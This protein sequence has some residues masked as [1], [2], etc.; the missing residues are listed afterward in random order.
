MGRRG[1]IGSLGEAVWLC[2]ASGAPGSAW[3]RSFSVPCPRLLR[4]WRAAAR[5]LDLGGARG[6]GGPL[7]GRL[8]RFFDGRCEESV[9]STGC[10]VTATPAGPG[11]G[12]PAP[13]RPNPPDD[14][15]APSGL[16][17][18]GRSTLTVSG[19]LTSPRGGS[20]PASGATFSSMARLGAWSGLAANSPSATTSAATP[21]SSRAALT[22]AE[23]D[24]TRIRFVWG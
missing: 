1:V 17:R 6:F 18:A 13:I 12:R 9:V 16:S 24:S 23:V 15:S 10:A 4:L 5:D 2:V 3:E 11:L 8:D 7:E 19:H 20:E 21:S 14:L 22:G